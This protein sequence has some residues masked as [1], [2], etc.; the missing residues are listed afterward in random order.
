MIVITQSVRE[1]AADA[2]AYARPLLAE[3]TRAGR[4]DN[5]T[6]VQAFGAFRD[7]EIA[8]ERFAIWLALAPI[9]HD[10][11]ELNCDN[12]DGHVTGWEITLFLQ[13]L[14]ARLDAIGQG[15]HR[16]DGDA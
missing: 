3:E 12:D 10:L 1:A 4:L 15:L 5:S 9:L 11:G 2:I 6:P 14:N 7:K 16:F 8:A 13:R